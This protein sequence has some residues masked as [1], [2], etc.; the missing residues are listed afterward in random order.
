MIEGLIRN[1]ANY[2]VYVNFGTSKMDARNFVEAA[3]TKVQPVQ[4]VQENFKKYYK[5]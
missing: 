2:W 1:S 5:S 3:M 4:K